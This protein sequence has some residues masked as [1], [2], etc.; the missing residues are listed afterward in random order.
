[1]KNFALLSWHYEEHLVWLLLR[2]TFGFKKYILNSKKYRRIN[3]R[4]AM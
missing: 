2:M 4:A 3:N 1:M